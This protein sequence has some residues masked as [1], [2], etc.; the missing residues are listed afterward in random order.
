MNPSIDDQDPETSTPMEPPPEQTPDVEGVEPQ[1]ARPL[2]VGDTTH[3]Q[4]REPLDADWITAVARVMAM[5]DVGDR[6]D[7]EPIQPVSRP[8][9][10]EAPLATVPQPPNEPFARVIPTLPS[11]L[12]APPSRSSSSAGS[13]QEP[14]PVSRIPAGSRARRLTPRLGATPRAQVRALEQ[15]G[16]LTGG[17]SPRPALAPEPARP[18]S[19][20]SPIARRSTRPRQRFPF[21]KSNR[22]ARPRVADAMRGEAVSKASAAR[23]PALGPA[24][25]S[26]PA[27]RTLI[28]ELK[29]REQLTLSLVE[30]AA[31]LA[32]ASNARL[33]SLL[34]RRLSPMQSRGFS[35]QPTYRGGF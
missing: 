24:A 12:V 23:G 18:P 2:E 17:R 8:R 16:R 13:G 11:T 34:Q 7:R 10:A 6:R 27:L 14:P 28:E 9:T 30:S 22:G 3:N 15:G 26:V 20:K 1:S 21:A 32:S 33:T 29:R 5:W 25:A 4:R 35:M 19:I 31:G